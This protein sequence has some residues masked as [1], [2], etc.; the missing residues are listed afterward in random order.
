[1]LEMEA[2]ASE[3]FAGADAGIVRSPGRYAVWR[4]TVLACA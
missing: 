2:Q 3:R 1:M 4:E